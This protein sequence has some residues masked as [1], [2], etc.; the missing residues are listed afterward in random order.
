METPKI[1]QI[2]FQMKF[3]TSPTESVR[4]IGNLNELGFWDPGRGLVLISQEDDS[5]IWISPEPL[6]VEKSVF[7]SLQM[8]F[9][10]L[11]LLF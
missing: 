11:F 1:C 5:T 7:I 2:T 4:I 6:R 3:Q 9:H 10:C 8:L